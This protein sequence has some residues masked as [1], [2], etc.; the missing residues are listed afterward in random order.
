MDEEREKDPPGMPSEK[1]MMPR[2]EP[3]SRLNEWTKFILMQVN[4]FFAVFGLTLVGLAIYVL[5]ANWGSLDPAFFT[6]GGVVL[7]LFGF[8]IIFVAYIGCLGVVNQ[9]RKSPYTEWQGMRLLVIYQVCLS[10]AFAAQIYWL[11]YSLDNVND[12]RVAATTYSVSNP[13]PYGSLE[14]TFAEKFN[15]FFFAAQLS[16]F[17]PD[18]KYTWFWT[19]IDK[20]CG[21]YN[22]NMS[23]SSCLRC[24]DY[25]VSQCDADAEHCYKTGAT[26]L[27]VA[28]PYNACRKGLLNL[29]YNNLAP[30]AYF[31]IAFVLFQILLLVLNCMLICYNPRDSEERIRAKN[32]IFSASRQSSQS[33]RQH[34]QHHRH[35]QP[36]AAGAGATSSWSQS[37]HV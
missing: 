12:L 22:V 19:I 6:G 5:A 9:R 29:I 37:P 10:L 35:H 28:C 31:I 7:C 23:E 8:I 14:T 1:T 27:S 20:V 13:I 15:A 3:K 30:F 33:S 4:F 2:H 21:S 17:C 16:P 26:Y 24:N 25:S 36:P 18:L 34:H 11:A 32:G